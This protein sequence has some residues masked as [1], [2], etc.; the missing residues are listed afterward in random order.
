MIPLTN[1]GGFKNEKPTND[2]TATTGKP[3]SESTAVAEKPKSDDITAPFGTAR[4]SLRSVKEGTD[5]GGGKVFFRLHRKRE[6]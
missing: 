6:K 3:T 2:G 5:K 4:N 1:F